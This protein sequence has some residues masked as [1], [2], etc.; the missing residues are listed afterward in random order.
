MQRIGP[1]GVG[2]WRIHLRLSQASHARALLCPQEAQA[3]EAHGV[4]ATPPRM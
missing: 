4:P 3:E 2:A 1:Q